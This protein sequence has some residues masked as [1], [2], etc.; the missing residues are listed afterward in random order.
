MFYY[1]F[2]ASNLSTLVLLQLNS[3]RTW[4]CC[5]L[6]INTEV[7]LW[8]MNHE[9][10]FLPTELCFGSVYSKIFYWTRFRIRSTIIAFLDLGTKG[11][12][13]CWVSSWSLRWPLARPMPDVPDRSLTGSELIWCCRRYLLGPLFPHLQARSLKNG[14]WVISLSVWIKR[15]TLKW[16]ENF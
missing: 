1:I 16:H 7:I 3:S 2:K 9:K 14:Y 12:P 11:I 4:S 8:S 10:I 13:A 5:R 6:L 15:L